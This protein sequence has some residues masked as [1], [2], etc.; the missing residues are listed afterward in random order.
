MV[1]DL[2]RSYGGSVLLMAGILALWQYGVPESMSGALPRPL[3]IA[4]TAVRIWPVLWLNVQTT[5]LEAALGLFWGTLAAMLIASRSCPCSLRA[6]AFF[7]A[8]LGGSP[9]SRRTTVSAARS[10]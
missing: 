10:P 9:R 2:A 7:P 8:V 6:A 4:G 1:R 5:A 3:L